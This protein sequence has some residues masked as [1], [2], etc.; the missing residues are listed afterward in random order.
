MTESRF[1][2]TEGLNL[3]AFLTCQGCGGHGCYA[4]AHSGVAR[5]Q[6]WR[7]FVVEVVR[8]KG[9]RQPGPSI[10]QVCEREDCRRPFPTLIASLTEDDELES[11][12]H[13]CRDS[14]RRESVGLAAGRGLSHWA[15]RPE[16]AI[17]HV[18]KMNRR[19]G[20]QVEDREE[21]LAPA[22]NWGPPK[23]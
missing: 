7:K 6:P 22:Q 11:V 9:V 17:A 12:C 1:A 5:R 18:A 15:E 2:P 16:L 3:D 21:S 19:N 10:W 4:C 23:P 13:W 20:H 8:Q 14:D